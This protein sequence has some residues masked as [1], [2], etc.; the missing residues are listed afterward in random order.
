VEPQLA[1][2]ADKTGSSEESGGS[3]PAVVSPG[4]AE[5]GLQ[6]AAT[7]SG[8]TE[9][10]P[11]PEDSSNT[12]KAG[13][14]STAAGGEVVQEFYIVFAIDDLDFT[15]IPDSFHLSKTGLYKM[16]REIQF[17]ASGFDEVYW[18][19]DHRELS[20]NS[21]LHLYSA[22]FF[23]GQHYLTLKVFKNNNIPYSKTI[24]FFISL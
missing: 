5:S 22:D 4:E 3:Q 11:A 17:V 10:G 1:A 8:E 2:P 14:E 18:Y 19:V 6:P 20:G 16:P 12:P 23:L 24:P 21:R 13:N 7:P 9:N 15:G